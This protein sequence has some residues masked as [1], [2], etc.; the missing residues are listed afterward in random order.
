M[1]REIKP[2]NPEKIEIGKKYRLVFLD[3]EITSLH[4][5]HP[6]GR[7]QRVIDLGILEI[8]GEV[9]E[10]GEIKRMAEW[11]KYD[12]NGS[13]IYFCIK[14]PNGQLGN[15][16]LGADYLYDLDSNL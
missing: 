3:D 12:D 6:G 8:N 7:E 15:V 14:D 10:V 1:I 9:V 5:N 4:R 16:W 2:T 11:A 13:E